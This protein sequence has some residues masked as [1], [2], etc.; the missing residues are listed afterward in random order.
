MKKVIQINP[1]QLSDLASR[2]V[3]TFLIKTVIKMGKN[4]NKT[5]PSAAAA[6]AEQK[7]PGTQEQ[8]S[9]NANDSTKSGKVA[10]VQLGDLDKLA[11]AR[12]LAGLDPN[13]T[14]DL[15]RM[16]DKRFYDDKDAAKRYNIA[17]DTVDK[18]NE[19][20][21]IGM[22]AL[23]TNEISVAQTPFAIA[24]RRTQLDAIREAALSLGVDID[25]KA[26]PAPDKEGVVE[27]PSTAVKISK[28]AKKAAA[29]E[30]AAAAK[31]VILDP[32]KIESEDQLK[33]SLLSILVKGNG[34]ENFYN[35]V[36]TAINFYESYLGIQANKAENKD[37][38]LAALK[39]KSRADLFSE[40][41]HLLGKC[42]F[43]ISG[44]AKFMF[45][46]T[47]RTKNPVVAF[48]TLR[49]AS[50]NEKTGMPQIDD[51]LVADIVK[52]LIRWYADSEIQETHDRIEG[53]KKDLEVLKKDAKKNAKAIEQGNQK[54]KIAE[55][56]IEDIEEVVTYAN[57]PDRDIVDTFVDKY[58][59]S[60]AEGYKFA[61]MMGSKIL[62]TYYPGTKANEMEQEN[63][64]HNL[65][66]YV[67]VIFN[68]FLPA[69]QQLVDFSEA[70]ITELVKAEEKPAEEKV[71][72]DDANAEEAKN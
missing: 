49:N 42:T 26:L 20:T 70:N 5:A 60:N 27:V 37:E 41:A 13:H 21:A 15:L 40:I 64:T 48:C 65:Q 8:T 4:K 69:M 39:E 36:A 44:M 22:V 71:N 66:Q 45:E 46:Q 59:D 33:D 18:I 67:G 1:A 51:S 61:R 58:T 16:L 29:E 12:A 50:L 62:D 57:V 6:A 23:L 3:S 43:T 7:A 38:L 63:L 11:Q 31:K 9:G 2:K 68:M 17:Q 28:E 25:M 56:H 55:K 19:I 24:M 54:I 53:F 10:V 30:R 14:E 47:E 35:K 34:S 72:K 32:T 52:V